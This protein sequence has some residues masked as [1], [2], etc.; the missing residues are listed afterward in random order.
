MFLML[1]N[2]KGRMEELAPH[3]TVEAEYGTT[4]IKGTLLTLAHHVDE[5]KDSPAPCVNDNI[6]DLESR[7]IVGGAEELV[8]GIS[9]WDWDTVGGVLSA[10]GKKPDGTIIYGHDGVEFITWDEIWSAI[11]YI[12][13]YGQHKA[14]E[15][16]GWVDYMECILNAMW[17]FSSS[18]RVFPDKNGIP[19]QI[20]NYIGVYVEFLQELEENIKDSV[21][22]AV[23][24]NKPSD[25]SNL[26]RK[27]VEWKAAKESLDE[28]SMVRMFEINKGKNG[29]VLLRSSS[30]FTNHLYSTRGGFVI[31]HNK[32]EESIT[33]SCSDGQID[34]AKEMQAYFGDDAGG[35]PGCAGTPRGNLFD[36]D[37]AE[38][39]FQHFIIVAN[40][41]FMK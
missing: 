32:T 4:C 23:I 26:L 33:L 7:A 10:V 8:I 17:A 11:A 15:C 24:I 13:V 36:I 5:F 3:V 12:D 41:L 40:T 34:C 37:D 39:F 20:N 25:H 16:P 19:I 9:H 35:Q 28:T 14:Y 6:T 22:T 21:Y 31:A 27:G 1:T 2:D 18:H 29:D 38:K 30:S